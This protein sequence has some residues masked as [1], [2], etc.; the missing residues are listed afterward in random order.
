MARS[1]TYLDW[2][3]VVLSSYDSNAAR[4]WTGTASKEPMSMYVG[5]F[6]TEF[7]ARRAIEQMIDIYEHGRD[8]IPAEWPHP[9]PVKAPPYKPHVGG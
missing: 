5:P 1:Y 2:A 7:E 9:T 3:V 8:I 6:V 4:V